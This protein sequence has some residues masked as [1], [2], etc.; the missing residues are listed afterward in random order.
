MIVGIYPTWLNN[1]IAHVY[2]KLIWRDPTVPP[3]PDSPR[4]FHLAPI[5]SVSHQRHHQIQNPWLKPSFQS[6]PH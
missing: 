1:I 4:W 2:V 3:P 5:H 6:P